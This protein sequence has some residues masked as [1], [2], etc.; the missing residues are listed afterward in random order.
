[1]EFPDFPEG[2]IFPDLR[3]YNPISFGEKWPGLY[4]E[5]PVAIRNKHHAFK[6]TTAGLWQNILPPWRP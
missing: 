3:T 4:V 5:F 6:A 1:M 2:N